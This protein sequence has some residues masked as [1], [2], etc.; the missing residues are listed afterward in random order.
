MLQLLLGAKLYGL[1]GYV[2]LWTSVDG[3]NP[4]GV[5]QGGEQTLP[6]IL[7]P[8]F[9]V[10]ESSMRSTCPSMFASAV[11]LCSH[12]KRRESQVRVSG[13]AT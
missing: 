3:E 9:T 5:I 2:V 12:R 7:I 11:S 8:C 13:H 4:S 6:R 10:R 1:S